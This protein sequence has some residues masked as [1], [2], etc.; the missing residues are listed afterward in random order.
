MKKLHQLLIITIATSILLGAYYGWIFI[1]IWGIAE[2]E[3]IFWGHISMAAGLGGILLLLLSFL[4][5]ER[6]RTYWRAVILFLFA[7]WSLGIGLLQVIPLLFW[8]S[9]GTVSDKPYSPKAVIWGAVPHIALL[10]LAVATLYQILKKW[11][12]AVKK[13]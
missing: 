8:L 7:F 13:V 12:T 1:H 10:L 2:E 3:V 9:G 4:L 5:A 11:P 6:M